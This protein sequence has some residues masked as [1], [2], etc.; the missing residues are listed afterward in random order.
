[1]YE[2]MYHTLFNAITNSLE[3]I[4]RQD[5]QSAMACL[6]LA[7]LDAEE[8]YMLQSPDTDIEETEEVPDDL[9][10]SLVCPQ[11]GYQI[12]EIFQ[13]RSNDPNET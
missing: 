11:C 2:S 1:M 13:Y 10:N 12:G 5:Y 7:C 4:E 9:L 3:M 6:E 8:I